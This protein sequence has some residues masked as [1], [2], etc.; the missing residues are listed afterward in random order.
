MDPRLVETLRDLR[1]RGFA[2]LI[3]DVLNGEP[4]AGR[5]RA[6]RLAQRIWRMEQ[7][8][9]RFSLREL[10]IPVAALGRGAEPGP[11]AGPVHPP[12]HG[13]APVSEAR[14]AGRPPDLRAWWRRSTV[15]LATVSGL[16]GAACVAWAAVPTRAA[17]RAAPALTVLAACCVAGSLGQLATAAVRPPGPG[18]YPG[19]VRRGWACRACTGC[20][21]CPGLRGCC[22]ARWPWRPST[23]PRRGIPRCSAWR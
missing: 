16:L 13:D 22:S 18:A 5:G 12:G 7:Q 21:G 4:R 17:G 15:R 9:I 14:V 1:Q 10:D 2:V 3:V 11:V 20:A 19:P 6:A 8:A 23:R